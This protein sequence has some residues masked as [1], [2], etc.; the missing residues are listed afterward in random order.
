MA[1]VQHRRDLGGV[2]PARILELGRVDG[3]VAGLSASPISPIIRLDG[4]GQGWLAT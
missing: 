2:E 4:K 3:D 1:V